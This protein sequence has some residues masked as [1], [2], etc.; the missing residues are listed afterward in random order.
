MSGIAAVI[1]AYRARATISRVVERALRVADRVIVVDD[2]C[3]D[4]CSDLLGADEPRLVILRHEQN[5]GVGAAMKTG[6]RRALA[7][8]A[9]YIVK[10]DA[11]DQMDS[12]LVPQ[13]IGILRA[14]PEIDLV[15]GNRFADLTTLQ[16][17]PPLRLIGNAGLTLLIK[18]SSGYWTVVDPTNGF[19]ALRASVLTRLDPTRLADRY[20]FEIDLLCALGLRRRTIA[21]LEMPAI[22]QGET[23]SLSIG[24]TLATF[25]PKLAARFIR[26]ILVN[27]FIVEIN[28][29]SLCGFI[30]FPLLVAAVI[31]GGHEW[32]VSVSS[33][34]GRATGTIVLALLLFIMGFQL[35]LQALLYD[36]QFSTR[37]V[38]FTRES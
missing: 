27:Y 38:K 28:V 13:M 20:F 11:D 26:R 22:Y 14:H 12:A 35:S 24:H 36:V 8:G 25:P 21:E 29:G 16:L 10:L 1:P 15:K 23:S 6:L 33:G 9:D 4:R 3:P 17:M 32:I 19:I 34:I 18:F 30:G 37:T 31:F 2:G 7:D 5:Q